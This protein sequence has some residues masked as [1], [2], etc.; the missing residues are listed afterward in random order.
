MAN[1]DGGLS[2][3][4]A[5]FVENKYKIRERKTQILHELIGTYLRSRFEPDV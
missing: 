4:A 3:G 1:G 5:L 2:L